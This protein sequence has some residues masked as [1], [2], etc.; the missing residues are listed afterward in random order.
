MIVT[1][2]RMLILPR[3]CHRSCIKLLREYTF[4]DKEVG[5]DIVSDLSVNF[6]AHGRFPWPNYHDPNLN[7]AIPVF[8][9]HGNHDDPT[10]CGAANA[11]MTLSVLNT[12]ADAGV[13]NYFGKQVSF[14]VHPSLSFMWCLITDRFTYKKKNCRTNLCEGF[15]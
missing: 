14:V 5:F 2:V 6:E 8:T 9:I 1:C 12:L 10:G 7:V 4:G 15:E 11:G 3:L 13:V